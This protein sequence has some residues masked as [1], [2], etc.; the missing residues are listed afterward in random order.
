MKEEIESKRLK[1][2]YVKIVTYNNMYYTYADIN[3]NT[4]LV[5]NLMSKN[6]MLE[7]KTLEEAIEMVIECT[8]DELKRELEKGNFVYCRFD[9]KIINCKE[10]KETIINK[11]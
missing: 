10:V 9:N 4:D 11:Y 2:A 6:M 3:E 8:L 7:P 1:G 5:L